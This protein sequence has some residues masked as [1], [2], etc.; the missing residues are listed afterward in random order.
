MENVICDVCGTSFPET[1]AQCPIC[2]CARSDNR[3]TSAGN[4]AAD[5]EAGYA[6]TKGG[7]FSKS[8]VRKRL[9]A[10]QIQPVPV[11]IPVRNPD[12]QKLEYD[13]YDEYEEDEE[14]QTVSNKGLIVIVVLLLL[15]IIAVSSYI[16]IVHFDIFGMNNTTVPTGTTA[17]SGQI[18]SPTDPSG[19]RIPC[20]GLSVES[21]I[22]L[23]EKGSVM[24]L[25]FS[26]DPID[27]TDAIK[28]VSANTAVATVDATGRVTAVGNGETTITITCGDFVKVCKVSCVL[29]NGTKPIDPPKPPD[30]VVPEKQYF[31]KLNGV[32]PSY[33]I[34]DYSCEGT[35]KTGV[36]FTLRIVDEEGKPVD[37]TWKAS[38]DGYLTIDGDTI[39]C[40]KPVTG[41]VTVSADYA[42][43]TYS[44]IVRIHGTAIDLPGEEPDVPEVPENPE[45]PETPE[46]PEKPVE[47]AQSYFLKVN[48]LDPYYPIDDYSCEVSVKV[49]GSILLTIENEMGARMNVTWT[50]SKDG[51]VTVDGNTIKGIAAINAGVTLTATY[52]GHTFSCLVRIS[53]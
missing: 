43:N 52:E 25:S 13:D 50:A 51:F 35:F 49:G 34:G 17:P 18:T 30:P 21:N 40:Y 38:K 26:V 42:G 10:A 11:E 39:K 23:V 32:N 2:G 3:Q 4:T 5:E 47:P 33:P 8:N 16:A 22:A 1:D 12:P 28:F 15:A 44:C 19:L 41:Y 45:T 7:R 29:D 20:T 14:E 48:N 31:L 53:E 27:T 24:Q 37:V 36:S 9:K 46:N 6:Y